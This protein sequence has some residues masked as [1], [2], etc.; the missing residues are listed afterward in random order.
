MLTSP[1]GTQGDLTIDEADYEEVGD[2]VVAIVADLDRLDEQVVENLEIVSVVYESIGTLAAEGKVE[3]SENVCN[4][5]TV[6]IIL[7]MEV[8]NY[9]YASSNH[10]DTK[11]YEPTKLALKHYL[12]IFPVH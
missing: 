12:F 4:L 1:F 11:L 8:K 9:F 7:L 2:R 3:I 10:I 5:Y 6:R